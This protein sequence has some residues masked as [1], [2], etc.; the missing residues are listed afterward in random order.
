MS[1]LKKG[2]RKITYDNQVY[3]WYVSQDD[4]SDFYIL[5]DNIVFFIKIRGFTFIFVQSY[6][7]P[8][9]HLKKHKNQAK[10]KF[11]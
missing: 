11:V 9:I 3:V 2:R 8:N 6:H 1:V 7:I 5:R 4:E 10:N